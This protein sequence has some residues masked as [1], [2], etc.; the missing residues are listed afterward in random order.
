MARQ[1]SAQKPAPSAS[2][3][4]P[5]RRRDQTVLTPSH[6]PHKDT[7]L[8]AYGDALAFLDNERHRHDR[9]DP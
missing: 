3:P 2:T 6:P 7:F 4:E 8:E 5:P 1:R 9:R